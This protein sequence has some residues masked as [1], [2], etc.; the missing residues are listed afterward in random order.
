MCA[1]LR[2]TRNF[3]GSTTTILLLS[4]E[5]EREGG[6]IRFSTYASGVDLVAELTRLYHDSLNRDDEGWTFT[7]TRGEKIGEIDFA[8]DQEIMGF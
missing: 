7:K 2:A 6:F 5:R 8:F 3:S 4:R 1:I